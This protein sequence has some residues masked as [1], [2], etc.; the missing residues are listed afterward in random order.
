MTESVQILFAFSI[1]QP[2]GCGLDELATEHSLLSSPDLNSD[3]S[4][5]DSALV[6]H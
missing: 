1:E 4:P 3:E 5:F 6:I 2:Y